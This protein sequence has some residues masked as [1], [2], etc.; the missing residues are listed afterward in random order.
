MV[1]LYSNFKNHKKRLD[2]EQRFVHPLVCYSKI[3]WSE[4]L[5][6][7][8]HY[9][10][11]VYRNFRLHSF[12]SLIPYIFHICQFTPFNLIFIYIY[13]YIYIYILYMFYSPF[14]YFIIFLFSIIN[15]CINFGINEISNP[16][17]K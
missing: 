6:V 13:I 15:Y 2:L 10:F 8:F 4:S 7:P 3:D 1:Y 16:F 5:L 12:V 17:R 14:F 11:V 9:R